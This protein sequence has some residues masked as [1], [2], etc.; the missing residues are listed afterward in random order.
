MTKTC[1]SNCPLCCSEGVIRVQDNI[2]ARIGTTLHCKDCAAFDAISDR[3]GWCRRRA[4]LAIPDKEGCNDFTVWWPVVSNRSH[5]FDLIPRKD[6]FERL[7]DG[8]DKR[9]AE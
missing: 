3:D 7:Q 5:C 1:P 8:I 9:K 2:Y 6:V 4:P